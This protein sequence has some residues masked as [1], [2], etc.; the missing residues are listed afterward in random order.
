ALLLVLTLGSG[1]VLMQATNGLET[2]W[3][4]ALATASIAAA[5]RAR[6]AG[7]PPE[8]C[9]APSAL[10]FTAAGA[11]LLPFL[12]PELL[13]ASALLLLYASRDAGWR[14]R[15]KAAAIAFAVSAPLVL[16]IR[17]DTGAWI[18]QTIQA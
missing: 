2:G 15:L 6:S 9:L 4:L 18:P 16:W 11:A 14:D 8:T 12:R 1:L 3:A 17:V 13:P 5:R 10:Y 7:H